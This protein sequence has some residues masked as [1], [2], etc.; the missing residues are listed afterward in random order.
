MD[1]KVAVSKELYK[2]FTEQGFVYLK[3]PGLDPNKKKLM[4][5]ESLKFFHLPKNAKEPILYQAAGNRGW[6]PI[7][8]E[9]LTNIDKEGGT[10]AEINELN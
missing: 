2:A 7:G 8:T 9:K 4:F 3:N 5:D 6:S 10:D 1:E